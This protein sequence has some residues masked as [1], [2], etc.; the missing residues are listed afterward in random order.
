[1]TSPHPTQ[2]PSRPP[3]RRADVW[4]VAAL[5]LSVLASLL[6]LVVPFFGGTSVTGSSDGTQTERTVTLLESQ[7]VGVLVPLGIP[8]LLML[9]PLYPSGAARR[10]VSLA[11][12][13]LLGAFAL[14]ALLSVGVFYLPALVCA[15]AAATA[16]MTAPRSE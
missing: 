6:L 15:I 7:G 3:R 13:V 8:V 4:Q 16:A 12:T 9:V 11:C 1:M 5:A 2:S 14:L 10:W